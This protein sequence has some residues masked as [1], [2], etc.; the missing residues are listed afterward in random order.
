[1]QSIKGLA[2]LNM[3]YKKKPSIGSEYVIREPHILN[4]RLEI[5]YL[6]FAYKYLLLEHGETTPD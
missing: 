4:V 3:Q 1:M 6:K 5:N 2:F